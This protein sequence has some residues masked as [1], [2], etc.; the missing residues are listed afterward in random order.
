MRSPALQ[1]A[2]AS[3]WKQGM[4]VAAA[5]THPQCAGP[6]PAVAHDLMP[7]PREQAG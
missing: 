4:V 2:L 7:T 1:P 5:W 3:K 6:A